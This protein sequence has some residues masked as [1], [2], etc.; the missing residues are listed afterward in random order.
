MF[1]NTRRRILVVGS[2]PEPSPLAQ[3]LHEQGYFEFLFA[4]DPP[5]LRSALATN[6]DAI[7]LDLPDDRTLA[8]QLLDQLD[9]LR[10]HAPVVVLS[11]A[12]DMRDYWTAMVGGAS[13]YCT[14]YSPLEELSRKLSRVAREHRRSPQA[15]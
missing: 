6:P 2:S 8:A 12:A 10:P 11:A 15:A 13:D 4:P 7:L 9:A 1:P 14:G 5:A 3:K